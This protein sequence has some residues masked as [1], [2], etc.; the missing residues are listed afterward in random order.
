MEIAVKDRVVKE[1]VD[2][3]PIQKYKQRGKVRANLEI[4]K[5][6]SIKEHRRR[7]RPMFCHKS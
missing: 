4:G 2:D 7:T 6:G 5:E 1:R 3:L